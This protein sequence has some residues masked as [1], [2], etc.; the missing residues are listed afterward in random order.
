M[1]PYIFATLTLFTLAYAVAVTKR[2]DITTLT[3]AR[4]EEF[5]P[6]SFYAAA[7]Y[8]DPS[9]TLTWSCGGSYVVTVVVL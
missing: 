7:A 2:Q 9:K 6:Y 5:K 8:C 1:L 4:I 3:Q